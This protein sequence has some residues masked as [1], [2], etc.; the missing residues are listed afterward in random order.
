MRQSETE[1]ER[2]TFG[3]YSDTE[4]DTCTQSQTESDRVRQMHRYREMEGRTIKTATCNREQLHRETYREWQMQ[5]E[6]QLE[7]CRCR[8]RQR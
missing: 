7:A 8:H 2:H 6:R 4:I 5:R 1:T 3:A